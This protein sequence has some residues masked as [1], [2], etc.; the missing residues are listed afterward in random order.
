[1]EGL[2]GLFLLGLTIY[3]IVRYLLRAL[4]LPLK[5]VIIFASGNLGFLGLFSVLLSVQDKWIN[6]S[7]RTRYVEI[8]QHCQVSRKG[9]FG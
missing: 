2:V 7:M 8:H 6:L 5:L 4:S 9:R 3:L 1:M